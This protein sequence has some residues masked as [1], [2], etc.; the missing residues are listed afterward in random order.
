MPKYHNANTNTNLQRAKKTGKGGWGESHGKQKE[1]SDTQIRHMKP[2]SLRKPEP[3][4]INIRAVATKPNQNP[5]FPP[6]RQIR[7]LIKENLRGIN[8]ESYSKNGRK[9]K[10]RRNCKVQD[11]D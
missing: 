6:W 8:Q 3:Q 5:R 9:K 11:L 10:R 1:M 7:P 2:E 4:S